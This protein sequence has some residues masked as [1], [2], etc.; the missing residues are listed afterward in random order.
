MER[1]RY[2]SR[3][4][5]LCACVLQ[6]GAPQPSILAQAAQRLVFNLPRPLAGNTQPL[7]D[8]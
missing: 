1:E 5:V 2:G 6:H 4:V 3:F 7:A 8:L